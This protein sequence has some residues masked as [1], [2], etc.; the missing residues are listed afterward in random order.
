MKAPSTPSHEQILEIVKLRHKSDLMTDVELLS[1][2]EEVGQFI[3]N[4]CVRPY[5][6]WN[7]RFTWANMVRDLVVYTEELH[8]TPADLDGQD[9]DFSDISSVKI[10]DLTVGMGDKYRSNQRSRTLQSH[11]LKEALDGMLL[12]YREDLNRFRRIW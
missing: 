2:I 11:D 12:N 9:L 1:Y 7:L 6:P 3:C 10:G 5:V 8:R 4:Y